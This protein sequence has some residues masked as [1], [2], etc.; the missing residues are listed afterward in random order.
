[1]LEQSELVRAELLPHAESP[2]A[3]RWHVVGALGKQKI[4]LSFRPV[5][6]ESIA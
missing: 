5:M 2:S 6:P 1:M 4:E 3:P